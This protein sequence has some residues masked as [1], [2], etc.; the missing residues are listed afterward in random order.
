MAT[1]EYSGLYRSGFC[2]TGVHER[3]SC[4][5]LN[6]VRAVS[7]YVVCRCDCHYQNGD[8]VKAVVE[9]MGNWD[10]AP[11]LGDSFQEL[12]R[13]VD[14]VNALARPRQNEEY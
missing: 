1:K 4:L 13:Y 14:Q 11:P 5:S 6:G 3:C 2:G 8:T 7:R 9:A 12:S 10:V